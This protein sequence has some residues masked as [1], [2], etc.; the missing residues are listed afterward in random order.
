MEAFFVIEP[1]FLK[2]IKN[3]KT[4]LEREP[5]EK[6]TKLNQL[7]AFKHEGFWHCMDTVR[8]KNNIEEKLKKKS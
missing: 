7:Y 3:D 4:Y 2:Y 6:A 5:L 8:D 1:E